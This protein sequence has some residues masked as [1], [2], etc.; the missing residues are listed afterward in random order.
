MAV[1]TVT[2]ESAMPELTPKVEFVPSSGTLRIQLPDWTD[3]QA[4]QHFLYLG[5]Y[6]QSLSDAQLK[7]IGEAIVGVLAARR[8]ARKQHGA[9]HPD[10]R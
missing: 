8:A 6:L 4:Q 1:P 9:E 10:G 7:T 2:K 3:G 5:T